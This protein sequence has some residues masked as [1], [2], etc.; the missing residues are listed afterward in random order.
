MNKFHRRWIWG[1]L[2][3]FLDINIFIDW[4]P[5]FIGWIFIAAAFSEGKGEA[6][7]WGKWSAVVAAGL[8]MPL[9][10]QGISALPE[11]EIP[12]WLHVIYFALPFA[13]FLA[14]AAFFMISNTLL[15]R[16][17]RSI[18]SH[19][20]LGFLLVWMLWQH[21]YMHFPP[22]DGED[23][24]LALGLLG[25]V[26]MFCFLIGVI[27]RNN[28]WKWKVEVEERLLAVDAENGEAGPDDY[29]RE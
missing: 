7:A 11:S 27:K 12:V 20:F 9:V 18:F 14:Y 23:T 26:L 15:E 21:V 25:F 16:R 19:V 4:L 28:E 17:R 24:T 10:F 2:F 5:D 13:E 22:N 8:S 29:S 3:I 6:A 1:F